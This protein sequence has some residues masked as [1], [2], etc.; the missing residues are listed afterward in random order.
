MLK[1]VIPIAIAGLVTLVIKRTID[2]MN[3]NRKQTRLAKAK[4]NYMIQEILKS[5]N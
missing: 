1:L 5:I 4:Y 2:R 3:N